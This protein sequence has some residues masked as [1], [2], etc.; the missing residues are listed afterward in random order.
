MLIFFYL[1][2]H[3]ASI[4]WGCSTSS[5]HEWYSF[6]IPNIKMFVTHY[7]LQMPDKST[8]SVW[9]YPISWKLYSISELGENKLIDNVTDSGFSNKDHIK[10]YELKDKGFYSKFK[11]VMQGENANQKLNLRI[12][13]IDIFGTIYSIF[14]LNLQTYH[15]NILRFIL[16]SKILILIL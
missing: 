15:K 7:S 12:Y 5:S 16:F 14:P 4:K 6:Y 13:K 1:F 11:L 3:C 8:N 2:R 10:T 9:A